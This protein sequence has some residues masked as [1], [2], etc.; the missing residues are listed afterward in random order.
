M[1][2]L[3]K[4]AVSAQGASSRPAAGESSLLH[5][6]PT[7]RPALFARSSGRMAAAC[8]GWV[9]GQ[10]L[11]AHGPACFD[12]CRQ[13]LTQYPSSPPLPLPL[14]FRRAAGTRLTTSVADNEEE[15]SFAEEQLRKAIRRNAGQGASTSSAADGN[16]GSGAGGGEGYG[17]AYRV[18][19]AGASGL[20]IPLQA[21]LAQV[22]AAAD[23]V[24]AA[25]QDALRRLQG[26]H[27]QTQ[28]HLTRTK[29]HLTTALEGIE[30]AQVRG[31]LLLAC[32]RVQYQLP[33][34]ARADWG[35]RMGTVCV[36]GS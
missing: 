1:Q 8:G 23:G 35:A 27:K 26:A 16:G 30:R 14:P 13:A 6:P 33:S 3:S 5:H 10:Q 34:G 29:G 20:L 24:S 11:A 2:F 17:A 7:D 31:G 4:T 12:H 9:P 21:R 18:P 32:K 19:A 36:S 15:E 28:S 22:K 25:L